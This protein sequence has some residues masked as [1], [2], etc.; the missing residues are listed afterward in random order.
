MCTRM[1]QAYLVTYF[2][3][4]PMFLRWKFTDLQAADMWSATDMV[5]SKVTPMFLALCD[6]LTEAS[7]SEIL[8]VESFP[9]KCGV[10]K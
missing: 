7:L 4:L 5:S 6:I 2:Q 1:L 10:L 9:F 3:I 8:S